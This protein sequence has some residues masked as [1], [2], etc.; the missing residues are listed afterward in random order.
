[1]LEFEVP[2]AYTLKE[3]AVAISPDNKNIAFVA[4][5]D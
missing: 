2:E 1:L 4:K 3:R 5:K